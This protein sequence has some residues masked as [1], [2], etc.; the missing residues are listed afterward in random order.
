MRRT[1]PGALS[2]CIA[3]G[4]AVTA[5]A[6]EPTPRP[7]ASPSV[8]LFRAFIGLNGAFLL[9]TRS[10]Y[11]R[12]PSQRDLSCPAEIAVFP[13]GLVLTRLSPCPGNL[14]LFGMFIGRGEVNELMALTR[15]ARLRDDMDRLPDE[16]SAHFGEGSMWIVQAINDLGQPVEVA[17][18]DFGRELD[19]LPPGL[20]ELDRALSALFERVREDGEPWPLTSGAFVR[21]AP[22]PEG[23]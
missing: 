16:A 5:C 20:E 3:L 14:N 15:N 9:R 11:F 10:G 1:C 22:A 17:I 6:V 12:E 7:T 13:D 21:I 4:L 19:S 2:V 8:D 23:G 18:A